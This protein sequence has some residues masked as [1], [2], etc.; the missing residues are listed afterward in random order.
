[1]VNKDDQTED[2]SDNGSVF[3]RG[4]L[5]FR[6]FFLLDLLLRSVSDELSSLVSMNS[7]LLKLSLAAARS[8][9]LSPP[10]DF[11]FFSSFTPPDF[12]LSL[13]VDK[14]FS[15]FFLKDKYLRLMTGFLLCASLLG[16]GCRCWSSSFSSAALFVLLLCFVVL[17]LRLRRLD[18]PLLEDG[19]EEV[20]QNHIGRNNQDWVC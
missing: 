20:D 18:V 3:G 2:E 12:L 9:S 5:L 7:R 13:M 10:A 8:F 17:P 14:G 16:A 1:M 19:E 15:F 6:T 4:V 11:L